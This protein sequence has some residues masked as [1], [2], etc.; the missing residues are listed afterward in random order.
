MECFISIEDKYE[1]EDIS[2]FSI[3]A[4]CDFEFKR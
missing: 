4:E 2:I 3:E 1:L